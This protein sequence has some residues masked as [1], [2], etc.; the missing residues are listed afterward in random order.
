MSDQTTDNVVS[1]EKFNRERGGDDAQFLG[2]PKCEGSEF[3]V[4]VR[5]AQGKPF[6]AHLVCVGEKCIDLGADGLEIVGGFLP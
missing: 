5:F 1:I 3:A 6:V 4:V 2:C